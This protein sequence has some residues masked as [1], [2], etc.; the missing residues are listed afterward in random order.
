MD[1]LKSRVSY[2][3]GLAD[4]LGL[5]ESK[6]KR[7]LIEIVK[8]LEEMAEAIDDLRAFS[9]ATQEYVESIDE[10]LGQ[11]EYDFYGDEDSDY[12]FE[13][14]ED[15]EEDYDD[16]YEDEYEEDYDEDE[17]DDLDEDLREIE[18]PKCHEIIFIDED[19]I[20]EEGK[21]ECPNC[22]AEIRVENND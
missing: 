18:C 8:V 7:L 3:K 16:E 15:Y 19:L 2:L 9:E 6:E 14:D 12:D 5:D 4:G 22:K 20:D 1:N 21:T 11:L 10:D 17:Y 13:E